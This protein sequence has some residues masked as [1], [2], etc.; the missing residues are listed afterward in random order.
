MFDSE[1]QNYVLNVIEGSPQKLYWIFILIIQK[2]E[3][4]IQALEEKWCGRQV[5]SL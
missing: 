1:E 5:K 3:R 2:K 4:C